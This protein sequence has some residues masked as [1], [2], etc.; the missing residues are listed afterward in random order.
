MSLTDISQYLFSGLALGSIYAIVAIGFTIIFSS[1]Q[2]VNF[3]QGE[4][5]MLGALCSYWLV[6][7]HS[8]PLLIAVPIA[9][10]IASGVGILLGWL[11][12]RPLKNA[13]VPALIIITV[14][15]SMFIQGVASHLW[16]KDAVS[17]PPFSSGPPISMTI[18][19]AKFPIVME[20]QQL[21][22]MGLAAALMIGLSLFFN[23]T[24]VGKAMRA[25]SVNR[26]GAHLV[27]INVSRMIVGS[28]ALSAAMGAVAGAAVAPISYGYFN[29]GTMM[30]LKGFAAAIVGGLGSFPGSILAGLLLGV[31]ESFAT[32]I[33]S[34]YK[35]AF[36]FVVLLVVLVI[37]P[38]GILS[39]RRRG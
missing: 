11:I 1:T 3:A 28:F 8:L 12:M 2:V 7:E 39:F 23:R 38:S 15:A 33:S 5:V 27:G 14:G 35:D 36:A 18:P 17:L 9:V 30:G 37:R 13:S 24:L 19:G 26:H 29:M 6:V 20:L 10:L 22:V 32:N 21:W 31:L 34:D 4:F 16:G 25:V